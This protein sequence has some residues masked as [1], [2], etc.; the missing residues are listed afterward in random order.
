MI[1]EE[2]HRIPIAQ[3]FPWTTD[4]PQVL[5]LNKS[6]YAINDDARLELLH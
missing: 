1:E 5:N 4:E 3:G 6:F 2:K